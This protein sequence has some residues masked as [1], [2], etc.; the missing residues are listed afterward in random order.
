[1]D[2]LK[3]QRLPEFEDMDDTSELNIG[4]CFLFGKNIIGQKQNKMKN[5]EP[6]TYYKVISKSDMGI[7]Y[8]PIYD[9]LETETEKGEEL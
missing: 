3:F 5:G 7:E 4:D 2:K 1:M 6:I 8:S 9:Y